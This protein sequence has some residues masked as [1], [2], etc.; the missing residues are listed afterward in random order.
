MK[1]L[2]G[3]E[4]REMQLD[5]IVSCYNEA[6]GIRQFYETSR[7]YA[8]KLAELSCSYRFFF[9]ND[10]S[11]DGTELILKELAAGDP[12]HTV[13]LGFS[14]NFGHEAAMLAGL[15]YATGDALVF[16]DADL[17][18]PPELLPEIVRKL[19]EGND[20]ISMVRTK[21]R[22]A[23]L[24][25]N[26]TSAGF[27]WVLNL[28][29]AVHF[30]PNASDFFAIS[31]R[32][33]EVLQQH[34]RERVR[35]LRGYVQNLGFRHTTI[36]YEAKARVAGQSHYSLRKLLAFSIHTILCFSNMPLKLGMMSGMF[37]GLLGL[38]VLFYTLCTRKSAPSGYATIVILNCFMFSILFFVVG[39][40]GE[41]IAVL[42]EELKDRPIYLVMETENLK[43][44]EPGK[45]HG[46]PLR[47]SDSFGSKSPAEA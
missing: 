45:G 28:L 23:G 34:Y 10:G 4:G 2:K 40:I 15:D 36:P 42:F 20:I 1:V 32:V 43:T 25:K 33:Q 7:R 38:L 31:R 6:A 13:Y 12:E 26:V 37:S 46:S 11:T 18:H 9:V 47:S 8:E 35:F 21:N 30:V 39:I 16:M 17:Q 14:K 27:Y 3:K 44:A 22:S 24:L 19:K 41:Y 29:S 5:I